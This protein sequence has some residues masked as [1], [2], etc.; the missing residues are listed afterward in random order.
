MRKI[1][2]FFSL[3]LSCVALSCQQEPVEAPAQEGEGTLNLSFTLDGEPPVQTKAVAQVSPEKKINNL[4]V[5]ITDDDSDTIEQVFEVFP[6]ADGTYSCSKN[7]KTGSKNVVAYANFNYDLSLP[8]YQNISSWYNSNPSLNE[9]SW[10]SNNFLMRGASQGCFSI[11]KGA[12]TSL[13]VA[14]RRVLNRVTITEITNNLPGNLTLGFRGAYL[15]NLKLKPNP[16]GADDWANKCGRGSDGSTPVFD[17]DDGVGDFVTPLTVEQRE[18]SCFW[19]GDASSINDPSET[20]YTGGD[21]YSPP[22]YSSTKGC[23]LYYYPNDNAIN[24]DPYSS[25]TE[26][27][28]QRTKL[29]LV[30]DIPANSGKIYYYPIPLDSES[31]GS[32]NNSRD[33]AI[34]INNLGV[35]DP[36]AELAKNDY[37]VGVKWAGWTDTVSWIDDS[38]P[39]YNV[40]EFDYQTGHN[41]SSYIAQRLYLKLPVDNQ[42]QSVIDDITFTATLTPEGGSPIDAS[43]WIT[44]TYDS[45]NKV[46]NLNIACRF[47]GELKVKALYDDIYQVAQKSLAI[48]APVG[49]PDDVT[50][51]LTGANSSAINVAWETIEGNTLSVGNTTTLTD[52]EYF[53]SALYASL[54]G[55]LATYTVNWDTSP[56]GFSCAGTNV[57]GSTLYLRVN[58]FGS[59]VNGM[60]QM[61][62]LMKEH[63]YYGGPGVERINSETPLVAKYRLTSPCGVQ[64]EW[65]NVRVRN[66]YSGCYEYSGNS[67]YRTYNDRFPY[68]K[69]Y[70]YV[71]NDWYDKGS[72]NT[73]YL[74][75]NAPTVRNCYH[76][77]YTLTWEWNTNGGYGQNQAYPMTGA[78][79]KLSF[80]PQG[81]GGAMYH[82]KIDNSSTKQFANAAGESYIFGSITNSVSGQTVKLPLCAVFIFKKFYY[83]GYATNTSDPKIYYFYPILTSYYGDIPPFHPLLKGTPS[84]SSTAISRGMGFYPTGNFDNSWCSYGTDPESG[85]DLDFYR[86]EWGNSDK[87]DNGVPMPLST[88]EYFGLHF[89]DAYP[90]YYD[91]VLHYEDENN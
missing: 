7:V 82:L 47:A 66:P 55:S 73:A 53:D 11:T 61:A 48:H 57:S 86:R 9:N 39:V 18:L 1:T 43:S 31:L 32:I 56:A 54:L 60:L 2:Y 25:K 78:S 79:S 41:Y 13:S 70:D 16:D 80:A 15:S 67:S 3:F 63:G 76:Y 52:G 34:T 40:G 72:G 23:R 50:L 75:G 65:A 33:F 81:S 62:R 28:P 77:S 26:Y 38:T 89:Y 21:F 64:T 42:K 22:C 85:W 20:I 19:I 58:S 35:L 59:T 6:N 49:T 30:C 68:V 87:Y 83:G 46:Y 4:F 29:V 14:L 10:N 91:G 44:T 37:D 90:A 5:I 12:T 69:Y 8:S 45:S 27:T 71:D 74:T 51:L 17:Y 88:K 84:W 24:Y 36:N